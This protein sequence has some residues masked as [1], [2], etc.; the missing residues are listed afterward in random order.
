MHQLQLP[1]I[2]YTMLTHYATKAVPIVMYKINQTSFTQGFQYDEIW[3]NPEF[4]R[5]NILQFPN[6][7]AWRLNGGQ[8]LNWKGNNYYEYFRHEYI[9]IELKY[10]AITDPL[11]M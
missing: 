8:P 9:L 2:N 4:K 10:A 11:S 3:V 1:C 5:Q 6:I 7:E